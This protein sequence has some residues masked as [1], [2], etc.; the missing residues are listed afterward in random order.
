MWLH[1]ATAVGER[2]LG[3]LVE[4]EAG[5]ATPADAEAAVEALGVSGAEVV[6]IGPALEAALD[7]WMAYA[8]PVRA[9][10]FHVRPS[11]LA[12]D[13]D[14]PTAGERVVVLDPSRAFG[15][16][17]HP[18]TRACLDAV[19]SLVGARTSVLDVGSGTGVLAIA[20]AMLGAAP[21]VAVDVDPVAVA[22]TAANAARNRVSVE[23]LGGSAGDVDQRFDVVLANIGAAAALSMAATLAARCAPG[24]HLVVAGLSTDRVTALRRGLDAV[25]FVMEDRSVVEGWAC[26]IH[27]LPAAIQHTRRLRLHLPE[28][29]R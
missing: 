26:C 19:A 27:H 15:S 18:S 24:G 13:D 11:W 1:G 25:G 21:V 10:G 17:D 6:D 12:D 9:G 8:R 14:P 4:L 20:A 5:F 16:G 28:G 22:A 7:A 23:A 2:A 3:A 29:D